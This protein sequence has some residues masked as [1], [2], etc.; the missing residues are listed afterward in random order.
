MKQSKDVLIYP[1]FLGFKKRE[2][3]KQT[4]HF[5]FPKAWN[6]QEDHQNFYLIFSKHLAAKHYGGR[7]K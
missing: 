6:L 3:L 4:R 7:K 1:K 5:D 2:I